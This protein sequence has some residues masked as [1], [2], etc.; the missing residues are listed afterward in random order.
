MKGCE[1]LHPINLVA[2]RPWSL[3]L[4][5]LAG[6]SCLAQLPP[7]AQALYDEAIA[8]EPFRVQFAIDHGAAFIP[9]PDSLS[10]LIQWFP[11]GADPATSPVI[12]TLH[13]H[14]SWAFDEFFEWY[15]LALEHGCGIIALQWWRGASAVP[16]DDYF[17]DSTIYEDFAGALAAINYPP[18]RALLH[19]FSRGSAV[20]YAVTFRDIQSGNNYFCTTLSN[21]GA[22]VLNYPLYAAIDAGV[23]GPNVFA[24]KQWM[25]YCGGLDT[26]LT[27]TCSAMTFS[28]NWLIGQGATIDLFIQ[29]ADGGHGGFHMDTANVALALNEY[30]ACFNGATGLP[31]T[32]PSS[33]DG[34][35]VVPLPF[36]DAFTI[37]TPRPISEAWLLD[38]AG[39]KVPMRMS[40]EGMVDA[41]T[42][43]PGCYFLWVRDVA[44]A[45]A[46]ELLIKE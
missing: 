16:P 41:G 29:D 21:A 31:A 1:V 18:G 24:G 22:V 7:V 32:A 19:G 37:V 5:G 36:Q 40:R 2:M 38:A 11:P 17:S 30:L 46:Q 28:E 25:L 10:F 9:T 34:L 14:S 4:C 13:G 35:R 3:L 45:I 42:I 26:I 44:G 43:M 12:V 20:S 39:R 23:Y 15:P 33:A 8:A 27:S 6:P